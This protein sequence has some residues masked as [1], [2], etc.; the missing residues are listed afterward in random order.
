MLRNEARKLIFLNPRPVS[1]CFWFKASKCAPLPS[2][3][4]FQ[5]LT[6]YFSNSLCYIIISLM[7]I[8]VD[9]GYDPIILISVGTAVI[10]V[11][12]VICFY[13][14][15]SIHR[16]GFRSYDWIHDELLNIS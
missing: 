14:Y 1:F 3:A 9:Y 5:T 10:T 8:F 4:S 16:T 15:D 11:G 6:F 2:T 7:A 13:K 12:T